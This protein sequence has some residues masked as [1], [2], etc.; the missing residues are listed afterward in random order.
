MAIARCG[1]W[2]PPVHASGA[3]YVKIG[4]TQCNPS[5]DSPA[6]FECKQQAKLQ[7]PGQGSIVVHW[8]GGASHRVHFGGLVLP[9][10]DC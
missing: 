8:Q 9:D 1:R 4:T 6:C 5:S 7:T 10:A 2:R 3:F